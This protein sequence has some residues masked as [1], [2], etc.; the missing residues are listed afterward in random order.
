MWQTFRCCY[1]VAQTWLFLKLSKIWLHFE[2]EVE[3]QVVMREN[4]RFCVREESHLV[5]R[6]LK[7][8]CSIC[9]PIILHNIWNSRLFGLPLVAVGGRSFTPPHSMHGGPEKT[10]FCAEK[11]MWEGFQCTQYNHTT[12]GWTQ[13]ETR[14]IHGQVPFRRQKFRNC[15]SFLVVHLSNRH[16][17]WAWEHLSS[18]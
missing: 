9:N 13:F 12:Q 17:F 3:R 16:Q 5:T 8:K 6:L 11:V 18:V 14:L 7:C 4:P 10:Q 15:F 1:H 2:W